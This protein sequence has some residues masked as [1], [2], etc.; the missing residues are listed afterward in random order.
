ME[1]F[2]RR[3]WRL[4]YL[5]NCQSNLV[6]TLDISIVL[7]CHKYS[8]LSLGRYEPS[9]PVSFSAPGLYMCTTP[10]YVAVY[11]GRDVKHF[12]FLTCGLWATHFM[13]LIKVYRIV[14]I[15]CGYYFIIQFTRLSKSMSQIKTCQNFWRK[16]IFFSSGVGANLK[17]HIFVFCKECI[18]C[19]LQISAHQCVQFFCGKANTNC[20][21]VKSHKNYRVVKWSQWQ[22]LF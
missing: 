16:N 9:S 13:Y 14:L 8:S 3:R 4:S 15:Y 5:P 17:L 21:V 20:G 18:F 22:K 6:I 1:L 12:S 7:Y 10:I 11:I 2:R 19:F